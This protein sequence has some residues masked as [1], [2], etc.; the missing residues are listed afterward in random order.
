MIRAE[1]PDGVGESKDRPIASAKAVFL[2]VVAIVLGCR[3][4]RAGKRC[5]KP[6]SH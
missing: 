3:R 6:G 1:S 4:L 2:L 5:L